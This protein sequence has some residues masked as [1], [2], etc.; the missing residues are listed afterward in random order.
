MPPPNNHAATVRA[1]R[2]LDRSRKA[3][4]LTGRGW[5]QDEIAADLNISQQA[6]SKLMKKA[7]ATVLASVRDTV[8]AQKVKQTHRL[9]ALYREAMAAWEKSKGDSTKRVRR[10]KGSGDG[11]EQETQI[12]VETSTG[13]VAY[14]N[15][16]R[17]LMDDLR[18]IWGLD[19]PVKLHHTVKDDSISDLANLTDEELDL[20][21]KLQAKLET[22]H[23]Q[24]T[25]R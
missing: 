4:E 21:A 9:E 14:L 15:L 25:H 16:A 1:Q 13:D 12:V 5:T 22:P 11:A 8:L 23:D 10:W 7:E 20:Y 17:S 18:K 2:A 19:A 3:W 6:V 24:D